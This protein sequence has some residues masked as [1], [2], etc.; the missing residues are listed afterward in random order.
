MSSPQFELDYNSRYR[1]AFALLA[2]RAFLVPA[3]WPRE[4]LP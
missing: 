4:E 3:N 2:Q 1:L